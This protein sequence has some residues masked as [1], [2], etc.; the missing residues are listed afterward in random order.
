M[1]RCARCGDQLPSDA[2]FCPR[3]ALPVAIPAPAVGMTD[4]GVATI[5]GLQT[6]AGAAPPNTAAALAEGQVFHGRY[7]IERQLGAGAMGVVYAAKDRTTGRAVALKLINPVLADRP[8]ARQRFVSEG[9]MARDVRHPNVVAM[10][11]VG[12]ADG[13]V[14]LVMEHLGGET[15]RKWLRRTL[16]EGRDV[17][18]DTARGIIRSVLEG[19][20]AA[21][22]VGVVHRDLKPENVMLLGD[23]QAGDYR[24][25]ILDFGIARAVGASSQLTTTSS[26]TGTPLYMAPEQKTAADTVGPPADLYAVTAMLYEILVGV[27]P[28]GRWGAPSRERQ[29]LPA[30]IDAVVERGLASRPRSRYQ[31]AEEYIETLAGVGRSMGPP[32]PPRPPEPPLPPPPPPPPSPTGTSTTPAWDRLVKRSRSQSPASWALWDRLSK[33]QRI[34]FTVV[35]IVAVGALVGYCEG[36][37]A[38]GESPVPETP[39][40]SQA[41]TKGP[42]VQGGTGAAQGPEVKPPPPV[43]PSHVNIAGRWSDE[44]TGTGFAVGYVDIAQRGQEVGGPIFNMQGYQVGT[45]QGRV[46]GTSME[47][48]YV[49]ANG[50]TGTGRGVLRGDAVHLDVQVQQHGTGAWERH[51]LHK[52]H[53]PPG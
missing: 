16:Q 8:S 14:Y 12:D 13:Q 10:Y 27:A 33:T 41:G 30:G 42:G 22:A 1:A 36:Q 28:E 46:D 21:H 47:Y 9:L 11:D 40:G 35:S 34:V 49:S 52:D 19:L 43:Q 29:D 17:A 20:A 15:L 4:S 7:T 24:L 48:N 39:S 3:C 32:T 44:V 53:W 2:L 38:V 31:S 51:T 50:A 26:S 18:F 45:F 6:I 23:P 25:K 37:R 5:S